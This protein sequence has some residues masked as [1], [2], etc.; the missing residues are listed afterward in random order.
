MQGIGSW[1]LKNVQD[2]KNGPTTYMLVSSRQG[3]K[4][5]KLWEFLNKSNPVLIF[6]VHLIFI[7]LLLTY[8]FQRNL[9]T[10]VAVITHF[11]SSV[12]YA[13][14]LQVDSGLSAENGKHKYEFMFDIKTPTRTYYLAVDT[15][16]EMKAWVDY[17]C[18]TCG[19]QV[20][21]RSV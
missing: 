7:Q 5:P 13:F 2:R 16:E 20:R 15:R 18:S 9:K 4:K 12:N 11:K 10:F 17:I 3:S 1:A 21:L 8:F 6:F 19:L 14:V